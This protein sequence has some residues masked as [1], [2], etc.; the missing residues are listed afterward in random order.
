[1]SYDK[2]VASVGVTLKERGVEDHKEMAANMC[3][4]WADGH[5]VERTFGR[6]ISANV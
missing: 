1:M 2:C 4:M 5:G 6:T 3:I